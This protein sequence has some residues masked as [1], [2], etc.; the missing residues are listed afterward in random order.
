MT[1]IRWW[2]DTSKLGRRWPS[3][4]GEDFIR[5]FFNMEPA[6]GMAGNYKDV[7][8]F[9]RKGKFVVEVAIP[10]FPKDKLRISVIDNQLLIVEGYKVDKKEVETAVD[11]RRLL[12]PHKVKQDTAKAKL[13]DGIL[14]VTLEILKETRVGREIRID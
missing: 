13:K 14:S 10:G 4:F 5:D 9:E 7:K 12:L 2:P 11:S 8:C 6:L 1:L 3:F